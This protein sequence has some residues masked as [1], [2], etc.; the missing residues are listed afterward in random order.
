MNQYGKYKASN[1]SNGGSTNK[2]LTGFQRTQMHLIITVANICQRVYNSQ[3]TAKTHPCKIITFHYS[4]DLQLLQEFLIIIKNQ[5]AEKQLSINN[6]RTNYNKLLFYA[7][8]FQ[9]DSFF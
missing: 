4:Y 5:D 6:I 3:S 7:S 9:V 1:T 2:A 8:N